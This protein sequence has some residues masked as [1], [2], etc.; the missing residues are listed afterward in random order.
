MPKE[1][2]TL[3]KEQETLLIPLYSKAHNNPFFEDEKARQILD[4]VQYDFSRLKVP[5]K[6][7]VTLC[8]RA[9]QLDEYTRQFLSLHPQAL[10]LHLGC[11]LDSRC[12]RVPHPQAAWVDLDMPDVIELRK[13]FYL[14]DQFDQMIPSSVTD[15]EWMDQVASEGRPVFVIAEGLLMY[16]QEKDV[17]ALILSLHQRF[18]GCSLAF[19]A[20][21]KL[22]AERVKAHPSLQKTGA[23]IQWG[24]DDPH[25]IEHWADGICLKEEWFFSQSPD[26]VKL[27]WFYQLMFRLTG[28]IPAAKKAQRLLYFTL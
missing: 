6:T 10:I 16:L 5:Q 17:R 18:P 23:V 8:M 22:T 19:D 7:V 9:K 20:F 3:T 11:G 13:K 21:S 24:I 28:S 2:I 14:Q 1:K 25:E 4:G 12:L 26:I 15:L 27:D